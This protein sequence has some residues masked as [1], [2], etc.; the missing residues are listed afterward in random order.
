MKKLIASVLMIAL[1][2]SL[3]GCKGGEEEREPQNTK[4]SSETT[5]IIT[6]TDFDATP[7]PNLLKAWSGGFT[8]EKLKST[9]T[10]YQTTC[11]NFVVK[12]GSG[13]SVSFDTDFDVSWGS[14]SLL[15]PVDDSRIET[16]LDGYIDLYVSVVCTD[17]TVTVPIDWWYR[18]MD[19]WTTSYK[20]WSYLVCLRD[21]D[22]NKH[23]YYFRVDYSDYA[24]K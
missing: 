2:A 9:I 20:V 1:L 17:R 5:E 23:Y 18:D 24:Q 13:S 19:S 7:R 6:E 10:K 4:A 3:V 22:G 15:S 16:E 14:V 21:T 12:K 11:T 8:E